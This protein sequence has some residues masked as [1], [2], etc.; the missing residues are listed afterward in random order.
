M[1]L[2]RAALQDGLPL[3]GDTLAGMETAHMPAP[4]HLL[5]VTG[6]PFP[7]GCGRNWGCIEAYTTIS[8]LPHLLA[9][10]LLKYPDQPAATVAAPKPYSSPRSQPMIQAT[11]SP[12]VA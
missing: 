8:G 4:L 12:S 5:G 3:E 1:D 2:L 7:C 11:N 10:K 9:E 6:K